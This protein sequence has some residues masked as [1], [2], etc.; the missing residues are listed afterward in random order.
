MKESLWGY[1]LLGLG[2]SLIFVMIFI[3]NVTSTREEDYYLVKETIEA[4]MIDAVDYGFYRETGELKMIKEKFVESFIR[5]FS[6]NIGPTKTYQI[7]FYEIYEMP[8]KASIKISTSTT[9]QVFT[10]NAEEFDI[11][12]TINGILETKYE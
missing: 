8:P 11:I 5:R 2:I 4:S 10:G 12:T 7:D 3:Q 9:T 1:L 6:E